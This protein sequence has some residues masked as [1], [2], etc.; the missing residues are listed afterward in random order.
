MRM[1]SPDGE[2]VTTGDAAATATI[3][4]PA[5]TASPAGTGADHRLDDHFF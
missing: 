3:A 4:D 2:T 1:A 5:A